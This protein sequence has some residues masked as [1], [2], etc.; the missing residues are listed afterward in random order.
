[1]PYKARHVCFAKSCTIDKWYGDST[2]L[3]CKKHSL[4]KTESHSFYHETIPKKVEIF[5]RIQHSYLCYHSVDF[6]HAHWI[7]QLILQEINDIIVSSFDFPTDADKELHNTRIET[8]RSL[9]LDHIVLN[10]QLP[11]KK[12]DDTCTSHDVDGMKCQINWHLFV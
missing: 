10:L 4:L 2:G 8:I 1:M 7:G 12:I 3:F 5:L 9:V 6:K 11:T